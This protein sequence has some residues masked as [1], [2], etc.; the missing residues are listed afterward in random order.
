M[1]NYDQM[2]RTQPECIY[3]FL[4]TKKMLFITHIYVDKP[5]NPL[6]TVIAFFF[7]YLA[8]SLVAKSDFGFEFVSGNSEG[9]RLLDL[10]SMNTL[11]TSL[12]LIVKNE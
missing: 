9:R 2:T 10:L 5:K 4:F 7:F 12:Q 3:Y 1:F 8:H 6:K 11:Q